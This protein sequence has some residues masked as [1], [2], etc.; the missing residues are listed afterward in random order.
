MVYLC[1]ECRSGGRFV[2]EGW[3]DNTLSTVVSGETVDSRFNKN[4]TEFAVLVLSVSFQMLSHANSTLLQVQKMPRGLSD[5]RD[6]PTDVRTIELFL[7]HE[8]EIFWKFWGSSHGFENTEDLGSSQVVG[9][10]NTV[11]ISKMDTNE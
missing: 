1:N 5:E 9:L 11:S 2:L 10:T 6:H 7:D 4:Q 3:W 8:V